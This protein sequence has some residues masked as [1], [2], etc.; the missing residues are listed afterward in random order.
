MVAVVVLLALFLISILIIFNTS[1]ERLIQYI[2]AS[3][4]IG[5]TLRFIVAFFS[6]AKN[7]LE[8]AK[9][10]ATQS[11]EEEYYPTEDEEDEEYEEVEFSQKDVEDDDQEGDD[12]EV[13]EDSEALSDEDF[14]EGQLELIHLAKQHRKI[15]LPLELLS[16]KQGKPT[17]GDIDH[18]N[19]ILYKTSISK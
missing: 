8:I 13:E 3:T 15:D 14:E 9:E 5:K 6:S 18:N 17:S 7:R 11:L 10:T 16:N 12:E 19:E 1:I 4:I 2:P